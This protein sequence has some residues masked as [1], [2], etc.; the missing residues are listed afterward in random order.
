M[1]GFLGRLKGALLGTRESPRAAGSSPPHGA[2]QMLRDIEAEAERVFPKRSDRVALSRLESWQRLAS[3]DTAMQ[4]E[5]AMTVARKLAR[6]GTAK[7]HKAW[8]P[9]AQ[10][11]L[12]T[13]LPWSEREVLALLRELAD[14]PRFWDS[15]PL[16]ILGVVETL[17]QGR[18]AQGAL[19]TLLLRVQS[20]AKADWYRPLSQTGP[21]LNRLEAMLS[22]DPVDPA[23]AIE[24][25][26]WSEAV[27]RDLAALP[28]ATRAAWTG[29][30]RH[31][32]QGVEKP[33]PTKQWL[34]TAGELVEPLGREQVRDTILPWLRPLTGDGHYKEKNA[35]LLKGL[36]WLLSLYDA[37]EVAPAIGRLGEDCLG[38]GSAGQRSPLIGNACLWTLG[39]LKPMERGAAEL[40]RL[41]TAVKYPSGRQ[42]IAKY[43]ESLAKEAETTVGDLAEET[44]PDHGLDGEGRR[45]VAFAGGRATLSLA[46]DGVE[47]SWAGADGTPRKAVPA[48]VKENE[49]E[50]LAVL[51]QA[52]KDLEAARLAECRRLEASWLEERSWPL[53]TWRR[54]F[55]EHPLRRPLA[56]ALIWR[57]EQDGRPQHVLP[58]P[59]GL[60]D[61]QGSPVAMPAQA[62]VSL[63]HPLQGSDRGA[64]LASPGAGPRAGPAAE[65]GT[66]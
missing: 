25:D 30:L 5:A 26:V 24:R 60:V 32:A 51:R 11:L 38:K 13:S 19:R 55:L 29:L 43:M 46:A 15:L 61:Q 37:R 2:L 59:E 50:A 44:L 12:R 6:S 9:I 64:R 63:W 17:L 42:Q 45:T 3:S 4:I 27:L 56:Q 47:L 66:P 23:A 28:D 41:A 8:K 34:A 57:L 22:D 65:A 52:A 53:E 20:A 39:N 35:R 33:K 1:S 31:A 58:Q 16:P 21:A 18:K 7:P 40:A 36:V 54:R 14:A 62:T 49:K 48:A 10:A